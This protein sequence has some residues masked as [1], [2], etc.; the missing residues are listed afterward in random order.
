MIEL[1]L[2]VRQ[3][4]CPLSAASAVHDVAFV[5]P[6]WHYHHDRSQLELRVLAEGSDRTAVE[7]GLD[8]I[9]THEET[10]AFEL[11]AKQGPTARARVTMGTT[12][13]MGTVVEHDGYLTGPFENVDGS[14]RWAI[15][16]DDEAAVDGALEAFETHD[17]EYEIRSRRRLDPATVLEDVRAGGVGATVLEGARRLTATE[18][19]TIRRAVGAGYYDVP[20]E[21]TLG[22]LADEFGISDAAVSKTLRRA[23]GKLLGPT[24]AALAS[25][26]RDDRTRVD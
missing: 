18:R 6:H 25:S 2:T 24:V 5:T 17:D 9:R 4:D 3:C 8:V 7:R 14:E 10:D 1:A 12:T 22:D 13:M 19:E 11:L 26:D 23:E 21:A 16:F 15:G 20:R